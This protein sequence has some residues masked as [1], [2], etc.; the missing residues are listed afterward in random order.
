M[1]KKP[2]QIFDE[3]LV[4]KYRTGDKKAMSL[5]IKRWHDKIK[6]QITRHTYEQQ[7]AEDI[8]QEVW[9]AILKSIYNLREP[10]LFGI[11]AM[12][13]ATRKAI[14]WIRLQQK[15]R[16]MQRANELMDDTEGDEEEPILL[17]Q[18]ALKELPEDQR[19]ILLL[20]YLEKYSVAEVAT[21][22][23]VPTGTV[24]SRLFRARQHLKEIIKETVS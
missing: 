6:R 1:K 21:I 7:V 14:D 23:E 20:F 10:A 16:E 17:L 3:L 15:E 8:A 5:L 22:I 13:I 18:Q 24:K 4:L 9:E 11:W 12:R 19:M 2:D